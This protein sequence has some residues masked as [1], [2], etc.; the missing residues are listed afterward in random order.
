MRGRAGRKGKDEVGESY[1]C[2]SEKDVEKVAELLEMELPKVESS[3]TPEKRGI[4]RCGYSCRLEHT[5]IGYRALLEV[6]TVRLA[7]Y[8]AAVQEYV[9][10]TLLFHTINLTLLESMVESAI[11]QL[12]SEGF[13]EVDKTGCYE[14]TRLGQAVVK[15]F[16]SPEDGLLV[17][18]EL[19]RALQAFVMDGEMHVFYLFT[20]VQ[21]YA[22]VEIDWQ[23]FRRQLEGLDDSG[24][25]A[26]S[27][28]GVNPG[29]VNRM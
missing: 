11:R 3:L 21:L 12:V 28:I 5:L 18:D 29:L 6:I 20:P 22:L 13:L 24:L 2:C 9:Q 26:L 15:S 27:F 16:M 23:L 19:Q 14:A 10:R 8:D 7:T 4:K 1:L 17:H 25:R